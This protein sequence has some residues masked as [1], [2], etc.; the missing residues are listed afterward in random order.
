MPLKQDPFETE[1]GV[2]DDSSGI[3]RRPHAYS[4]L[5]H[6]WGGMAEAGSQQLA[7]EEEKLLVAGMGT[8][9]GEQSD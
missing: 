6:N 5:R 8:R 3:D 9:C 2:S 1:E 7:D 4:S